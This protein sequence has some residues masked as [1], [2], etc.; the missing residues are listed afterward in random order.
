MESDK[1]AIPVRYSHAESCMHLVDM[2][3]YC[4]G[5]VKKLGLAIRWRN[6]F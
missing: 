2:C 6:G 4:E 1:E 3:V 5:I